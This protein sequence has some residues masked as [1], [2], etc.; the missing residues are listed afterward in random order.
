MISVSLLTLKNPVN[1]NFLVVRQIEYN[2][3]LALNVGGM[4]LACFGVFLYNRVKTNLRKIP[5][6]PTF[7]SPP[8]RTAWTGAIFYLIKSSISFSKAK[9]YK[10]LNF[11]R[12]NILNKNFPNRT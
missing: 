3:E 9:N 7:S 1:G 5:V 8:M 2:F 4:V 10:E 11:E 6:L 12:K